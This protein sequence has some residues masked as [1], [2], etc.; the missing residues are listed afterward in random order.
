MNIIKIIL[1]FLMFQCVVGSGCRKELP[2]EIESTSV[3]N[4]NTFLTV[5]SPQSGDSFEPGKY[6]EIKWSSSSSVKRVKLELYNNNVLRAILADHYQND[7]IYEW[8]IPFAMPQ[9][10]K[11]KVK[12]ISSTDTLIYS[13]SGIFK[14][15]K[16]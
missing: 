13:F 14:I 7:G 2:V 11:Y 4:V 10:S 6:M 12:I 8:Y 9:S 5:T 3:D 1:L 16:Q 15:I